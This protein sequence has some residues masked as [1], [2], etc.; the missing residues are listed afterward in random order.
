MIHSASNDSF[1]LLVLALAL[2]AMSAAAS[3]GAR[4][5]ATTRG[6]GPPGEETDARGRVV[7]SADGV[8]KLYSGPEGPAVPVRRGPLPSRAPAVDPSPSG[9]LRLYLEWYRPAMGRAIGL[10]GLEVVDLDGDGR[11]EIVALSD[12]DNWK[13]LA[14]QGS[15]Y[16]Q[17]W[18]SMP[19]AAGID[20]LRV[21]SVGGEEVIVLGYGNGTLELIAGDTRTPFR[22]IPTGATELRGLTIANLDADR[23]PE[24]VFC[25]ADQI[26]IVD[27]AT[28]AVTSWSMACV[29]LAVGQVDDEP[30]LE[31][32]VATPADP[33]YVL[34]AASGAIEWTNNLGFGSDV[35][36]GDLDGDGRDEV[37]AGVYWS[38]GITV[39]NV[40]THSIGY[41]IP[42]FNLATMRILNADAD[43][44]L[45][46]LYGDAQWGEVHV[47]NG[48]DGTEDWAINNPEHGV[49]GIAFGNVDEDPAPEVLWGA[50]AT[51][52][53]A[54]YLFV[55]D[56]ATHLQEWHSLDLSGGYYALGGGDVDA[57]GGP[58]I[59]YG[60]MTSDSGY[61][62][63][64]YFIHDGATKALEQSGFFDQFSGWGDLWRMTTAD[65]MGDAKHEIFLA[66]SR[67]YDG[68]LACL[69]LDGAEQWRVVA[70]EGTSFRSLGVANVD[71]DSHLEVVASVG[72][73][74]TGATAV[75]LY[76]YDAQNGAP[77]W[78][79]PNMGLTWN[80]Y[81][82]LRLAQVDRDAAIETVLGGIGGRVWVWD[83]QSHLNETVSLNLDVSALDV[84][85]V[86]GDGIAEIFIGT[87]TGLIRRIDVATGDP[88]TILGPLGGQIDGLVLHDFTADG[89][90][91]YVFGRG[92][93]IEVRDGKDG[94]PR[95]VSGFL[96]G[97]FV[98]DNDTLKVGDFDGDGETEILASLSRGV[99]LF[100]DDAR[101][102]LLREG[103]ESGSTFK[104][105]TSP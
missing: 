52:S 25:D 92:T 85:D 33:A 30:G 86:D 60:S 18:A 49:T 91:D 24:A 68:E 93:Q 12:L 17:I 42:I 2:A 53:G 101:A 67:I 21:A 43:A 3:V 81:S 47:L 87:S 72:V 89:T 95:W 94:T 59:F 66:G 103:F 19:A 26:F 76:V 57:D 16:E 23:Q 1:R 74:H 56:G 34:D 39:F 77:E 20:A 45:E 15:G 78:K 48:A 88:T 40:E 22:T 99:A 80:G 13:V 98:A 35:E 28:S 100:G 90:L 105:V 4:D 96:D 102:G 75:S 84:A 58:E 61:E 8:R 97:Y 38:N 82:L 64:R 37:A 5:G 51:S 27:L 29:D 54:D 79:S 41:T 62:N 63:G 55:G 10:G 11:N 44:P 50:G 69:D 46:L 71:A 104:W 7:R 6:G 14:R 70:D 36:V 32:V 31:I 83:M 73:E 65:A 9:D